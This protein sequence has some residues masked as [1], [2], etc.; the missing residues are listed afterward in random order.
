MY[1]AVA[2]AYDDLAGRAEPERINLIIVMTDG[3]S[4]DSID[5]VE[6]VIADQTIP[7]L[8]F[9]VAYGDDAD[10]DALQQLARLGNGHAYLSDTETIEQLYQLLSAFIN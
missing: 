1:E 5:L 7:V 6:A 9:T 8:I 3:Q 4:A 10:F 2:L